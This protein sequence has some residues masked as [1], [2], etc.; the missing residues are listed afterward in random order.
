MKN[1][2]WD[3]TLPIEERLDALLGELTLEEKIQSLTV[4][5]PEI[6][7]LGIKAFA[8]GSEAAHGVQARHDEE[9]NKE[10]TVDTTTFNQPI[11]MSMTW[12]P[13]LI[14]KAGKVTGVEAR[15]IFNQ[16]GHIGLSRWA[17]TVDMERDPRWGRNEEGY[18]E[19]PYLTGKMASAYIKGM[20]GEDPKYIQCAATLK[21]FYANNQEDNREVVS[22][23]IDV[24]N[25]EE[26]YLE[27]FRRCIKE[28]R[29]ESVMTSY[30]A[31]NGIPS[32]VNKEVKERLKGEFGL[33]GHVVCDMTDFTQTADSHHFTRS[34]AETISLAI[35]AGV[36]C[37][38]DT[39]ESIVNAAK[40]AL[41]EGLLTE[42]EI[43]Q[44]L[45]NSFRTRFRLGLMD[46]KES[47]SYNEI[48]ESVVDCKEHREICLSVAKEAMVLLQNKENLLPFD[49]EKKESIAVIGPM[50]DEW[51]MDWYAGNPPYRVTPLGGIQKR[52]HNAKI[53]YVNGL[54]QVRIQAGD[55]Y[56][57]LRKDGICCLCDKED[58]EIFEYCNWGQNKHTLRSLSTGRYLEA[59]V[60]SAFLKVNKKEIFSW[61][62]EEVFQFEEEENRFT[63]K[64]WNGSSVGVNGQAMLHAGEKPSSFQLE[65]V[66]SGVEQAVKQAKEADKVIYVGGCHPIVCGKEAIDRIDMKLPPM[67]R[68]QLQEISKVNQHTVFVLI[69][70]YPYLINWEK[71]NLKAILTTSSGSQELGNAIA[72]ALAGDFSP[73]GRL[74]MTWYQN[75]N[76]ITDISDYDIIGGKRT[77]QY[78]EKEPLYP[79]GYGLSYTQFYYSDLSVQLDQKQNI[80]VQ[81][82]VTNKG[83]IQSDEVVQIYVRQLDSRAVHPI[84]KLVGFVRTKISAGETREISI[85]IPYE[86]LSYYDVVSSRR[87]VEEG[88]YVIMAGAS[89]DDI[90]LKETIHISGEK[91][92]PRNMDQ[93]ICCDHFDESKNLILSMT[94][95]QDL[96]FMRAKEGM[97]GEAVYRDVVFHQI[98]SV[99]E[100]QV[101]GKEEGELQV[102]YGE[103]L[104][105]ST[106]L[107]GIDT[108]TKVK[109]PLTYQA[110]CESTQPLRLLLK[111]DISVGS[112]QFW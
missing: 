16:Q 72:G 11:G 37:F 94:K 104:L 50:A 65:L 89:S 93:K 58:A 53:T 5:T 49:P 107:A 52:F 90:R 43:D 105:L 82:M 68:K 51:C 12:D 99:M 62:V 24:R 4:E 20:Q 28:G 47:C 70:N 101:C 13:E 35:K 87:L 2:I 33:P 84:K 34:H 31:V 36:D 19:D 73:A 1:K 78:F 86:E 48:E 46:P 80:Q 83:N 64:T 63:W 110:E 59:D 25:K 91:I 100:V 79:F 112:F 97:D 55:H 14:Q 6:S 41:K 22:S 40:Q 15:A 21:H 38:T 42:E 111:G 75:E 88:E 69:T 106:K 95:E 67:Q 85:E 44:A 109:F 26:Y 81:L 92:G 74:N 39:K 27:P 7:R 66:E 29:V 102:I 30:N 17:P 76:E 61:F 18:G 57:G 45:R 108:F 98:P 3:T 23:S 96:L 54:D 10:K 9:F 56:V 77:Y 60:E 32:I 71:E 8:I 103:Q